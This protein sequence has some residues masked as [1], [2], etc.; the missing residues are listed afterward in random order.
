MTNKDYLRVIL[1]AMGATPEQ[2]IKADEAIRALE[3]ADE[4]EQQNQAAAAQAA[5]EAYLSKLFDQKRDGT[6]FPIKGAV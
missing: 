6:H 4:M 1:D 5:Q 3:Q 2:K